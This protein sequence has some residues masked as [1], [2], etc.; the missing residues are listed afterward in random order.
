MATKEK[1]LNLTKEVEVELVQYSIWSC[2]HCK[3][4]NDTLEVLKE[5]ETVKC[6]FCF[7]ESKIGEVKK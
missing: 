5:G 7:I 4:P 6:S 2:P 3:Y 1:D